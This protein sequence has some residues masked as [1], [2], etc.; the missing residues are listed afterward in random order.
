MVRIALVVA[1]LAVTIYAVADWS[2]TPEDEMPGRIPKPMWLVII[3]FTT[4]LFAVGAI[5]W[6]VLR[7]VNRAEARGHRPPPGPKGPVAPDD[8]PEFL[9]R[10]ERDIQRKR[11]QEQQRRREEEGPADSH[12]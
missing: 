9:F 8:D 3:V 6:L 11:R 5:A 12:D 4:M 7:W 2:R 10:L 1:M